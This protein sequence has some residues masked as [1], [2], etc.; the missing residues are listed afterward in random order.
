MTA[1]AVAATLLFLRTADAGT[2]A[3]QSRLALV[4]AGQLKRLT[5]LI[6]A[7]RFYTQN[8]KPNSR[9]APLEIIKCGATDRVEPFS[10]QAVSCI[11]QIIQHHNTVRH[12]SAAVV[13]P[14]TRKCK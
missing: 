12:P 5:V 8:E 6:T 7:H 1:L 3:A 13:A 4:L 2:Q 14:A 10:L 9:L 11:E